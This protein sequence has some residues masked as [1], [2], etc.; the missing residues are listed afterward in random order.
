MAGTAG[1]GIRM[2]G[3]GLLIKVAHYRMAARQRRAKVFGIGMYKTG[4]TSLGAALEMLGY[5]ATYQFWRLIDDWTAYF[6]LDP[7]QWSRFD[8]KIRRSGVSTSL[9]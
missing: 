8:G 7:N 4:T 5:R 9:R 1:V 2:A 6:N 3:S